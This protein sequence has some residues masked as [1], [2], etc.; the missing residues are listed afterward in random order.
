MSTGW[1]GF[2]LAVIVGILCY[3]AVMLTSIRMRM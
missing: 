1:T 3:I 2:D